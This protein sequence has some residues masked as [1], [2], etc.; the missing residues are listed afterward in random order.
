MIAAENFKLLRKKIVTVRKT[1]DSMIA[2]FCIKNEI[3][4]LHNDKDFESFVVHL[5]LKSIF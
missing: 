1:M 3:D 4:L 2:T 5:V